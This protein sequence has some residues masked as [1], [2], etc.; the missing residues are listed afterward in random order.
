MF[1]SILR[2]TRHGNFKTVFVFQSGH[3]LAQPLEKPSKTRTSQ[4]SHIL[5]YLFSVAMTCF[6]FFYLIKSDILFKT[7][8]LWLFA[9]EEKDDVILKKDALCVL[10]SACLHT[11]VSGTRSKWGCRRKCLTSFHH[12]RLVQFTFVAWNDC[13]LIHQWLSCCVVANQGTCKDE[14]KWWFN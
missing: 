11:V 4:S 9:V 6:L 14:R 12:S 5:V 7:K 8:I 2:T 1:V 3:T 13:A 10:L